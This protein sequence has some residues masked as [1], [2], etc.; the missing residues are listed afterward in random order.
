MVHTELRYAA[1]PLAG[2]R[3]VVTR[4]EHQCAALMHAIAELGGD[5]L[6]FPVMTISPVSD[7]SKIAAVAARLNEFS[8]AIFVSP[9]AVAYGMRQLAG[10]DWPSGLRVAT[11][12]A[13]SAGALAAHGFTDV[14]APRERF[15][16]EALLEL[17]AL[18]APAVAGKGVLI[19]RGDG[20]RDLLDRTLRKRGARVELLACYRR[21]R[22]TPSEADLELWRSARLDAVTLTSSEG[23][24]NLWEML[25]DAGRMRLRNLPVLVPHARIAEQARQFGIAH[26]SV[27]SPGDAGLVEALARFPF[28][29]SKC[30]H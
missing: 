24:R 13:S 21:G 29:D 19:L 22:P 2:R 12:G 3:I 4:P 8:L 27:T 15:D 7:L 17:D 9:N 6:M 10:R 20:G 16:S 25:D 23:L 5:P 30:P 1:R 18:Q 11:V 14:I 26:V 28:E